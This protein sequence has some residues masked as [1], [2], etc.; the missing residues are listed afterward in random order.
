MSMLAEGRRWSGGVARE[1]TGPQVMEIWV[2]R[3]PSRDPGPAHNATQYYTSR[4][5]LI[6]C[7]VDYFMARSLPVNS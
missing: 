6:V 1:S 2:T 3:P 7:T 4:K 5:L